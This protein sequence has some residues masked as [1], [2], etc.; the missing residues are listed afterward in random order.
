M[1]VVAQADETAALEALDRWV[2]ALDSGDGDRIAA[3]YA[4]DAVL[5]PTFSNEMRRGRAEISPYFRE[6][7]ETRPRCRLLDGSARAVGAALVHSGT[8]RFTLTAVAGQPEIEARFTFVYE[9]SASGWL[10][11]THHSSVAGM[12]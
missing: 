7:V 3:L 1:A 8:Y 2:E 10:I 6:F 12:R 4:R 11:V 9:R 5:V